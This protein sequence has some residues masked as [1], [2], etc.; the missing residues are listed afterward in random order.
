MC[1]EYSN[2]PVGAIFHVAFEIWQSQAVIDILSPVLSTRNSP[3][4]WNIALSPPGNHRHGRKLLGGAF[5]EIYN[6]NRMKGGSR[7]AVNRIH[8]TRLV[9]KSDRYSSELTL[10]IHQSPCPHHLRKPSIA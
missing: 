3:S 6:T 8:F 1:D 10:V 9:Q 4:V 5:G 2:R 7:I